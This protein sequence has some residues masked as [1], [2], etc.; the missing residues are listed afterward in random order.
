MRI[1]D[2]LKKY[3]ASF[4]AGFGASV[5]RVVPILKSLFFCFLIPA[6]AFISILLEKKASKTEGKIETRRGVLLGLMTGVYAAIFYTIF[7][8]FITFVTNS[9]D[10][11]LTF[12]E[13]QSFLADFLADSPLHDEIIKIMGSIVDDIQNRGFSFL[14]SFSV[15]FN[16]MMMDS[17]FGALGGLVGVHIINRK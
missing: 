17:I 13:F 7:E 6:A 9:N 10:F 5:I 11:V 16:S 4:V 14:Y 8:T 1:E 2:N 3:T 12:P 15:F